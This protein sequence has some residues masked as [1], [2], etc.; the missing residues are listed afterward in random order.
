[1]C[2]SVRGPDY[3]EGKSYTATLLAPSRGASAPKTLG[4]CLPKPK[5]PAKGG[6]GGGR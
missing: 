6:R 3:K 5:S 1:M 4:E 2:V